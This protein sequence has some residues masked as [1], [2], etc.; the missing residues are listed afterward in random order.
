MCRDEQ[1]MSTG[2]YKKMPDC[3]NL[4]VNKCQK[5]KQNYMLEYS[6]TNLHTKSNSPRS[7]FNTRP[8]CQSVIHYEYPLVLY[9]SFTW[10]IYYKQSAEV[11]EFL[12]NEE[13]RATKKREISRTSLTINL[14]F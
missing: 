14:H 10:I 3:F 13:V 6:E 2:Q 11:E 5:G 1:L 4:L 8:K 9:L 7:L 12:G